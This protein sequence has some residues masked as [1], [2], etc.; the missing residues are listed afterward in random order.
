MLGMLPSTTSERGKRFCDTGTSPPS[1]AL[2]IESQGYV[3]PYPRDSV[4]RH[5]SLFASTL[6]QLLGRRFDPRVG[7]L[8]VISLLGLLLVSIYLHPSPGQQLEA[9]SYHVLSAVRETAGA[10]EAGLNSAT[11]AASRRAGAAAPAQCAS[12]RYEKMTCPSWDPAVPDGGPD[13]DYRLR[14]MYQHQHPQNCS[15]ENYLIRALTPRIGFGANMV[16]TMESSM[17]MA[18]YT[19]RIFLLDPDRPF[20]YADCQDKQ[21][22]CYFQPLSNCTIRD[23]EEITRQRGGRYDQ[24]VHDPAHRVIRCERVSAT[25]LG[26][27]TCVW[28]P[29]LAAC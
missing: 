10:G 6:P 15:E 9:G 1:A 16:L 28:H 25:C 19:N 12:A 4:N 20:R 2:H 17:Y 7:S 14:W 18:M 11:G 23:A 3:S 24:V 8:L 5:Q 27:C 13:V 21:W 22:D 26:V 29:R